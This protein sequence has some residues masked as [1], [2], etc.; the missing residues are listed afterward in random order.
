[1]AFIIATSYAH[2]YIIVIQIKVELVRK[3]DVLPIRSWFLYYVQ[4]DL[5]DK[6]SV[7]MKYFSKRKVGMFFAMLVLSG[8]EANR[9]PHLYKYF[10]STKKLIHHNTI[11]FKLIANKVI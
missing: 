4:W 6:D 10:S 8:H 3:S 7:S 9:R 11:M 1:M 5:K 2:A